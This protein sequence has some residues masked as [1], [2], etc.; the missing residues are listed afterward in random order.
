MTTYWFLDSL[1]VIKWVNE[2]K[3]PL[4]WCHLC[5]TIIKKTYCSICVMLL[6]VAKA[7][8]P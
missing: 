2:I 4:Q 5:Y 3:I 7:S 1:N 8:K 6:K